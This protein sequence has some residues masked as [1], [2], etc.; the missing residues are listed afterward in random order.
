[1][2][3]TGTPSAPTPTGR[4][5]QSFVIRTIRDFLLALTII[6]VVEL[7]GRLLLVRYQ[8]EH[9]DK[10]AT[11]LDADRLATDLKAIMLNEGGPVAARTVYPILERN[12]ADLGLEIAIAPSDLTVRSIQSRFGFEPRGVQPDWP[13]GKAY[14][15][16]TVELEAEAFC[17]SCHFN[18]KVGDV[19]GSVTVRNYRST[20]MGEWWQE[21]RVVSVV[22]MANV[23]VHTIVLFLLLRMRME[24]LLQLRATVARLAKGRLDL[25]RRAKARSDDEFG[26]L[27]D[28]L[29]HFLDRVYHLVED[30]DDVLK[31]VVAV[32]QRLGR[33]STAMGEQ[34]QSVQEKTQVAIQRTVK[35][36]QGVVG[37]SDNTIESL[38]VILASLRETGH[39]HLAEPVRERLASLIERF[40]DSALTTRESIDQL[41]G[42]Q[43][44]LADLAHELRNDTHYMG[45]ILVL[46]E[47]MKVVSEAGQMLLNRLKGTGEFATAV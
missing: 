12:H 32:N 34:I 22:G 44:A 24:P 8:F 47:R 15:E 14:H 43:Q 30:L 1:M 33:V 2:K 25:S 36:Q 37:R 11:Q 17:T 46:E 9:Q 16:A 35:I 41:G 40:R 42:L 4:F 31:Q 26:E 5:D 27:A 19:L 10:Q 6:I 29:N 45:E 39:G 28:D 20:R 18:A 38:D 13:D 21:A 7:G 3:G 23:I